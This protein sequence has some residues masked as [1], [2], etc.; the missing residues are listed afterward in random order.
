MNRPNICVRYV[1]R[2]LA[3]ELHTR[4]LLDRIDEL[5][6]QIGAA[7]KAFTEAREAR[8][9]DEALGAPYLVPDRS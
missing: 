5:R 2:D 6:D 4:G 9:L 8:L 1:C 3:R 7:Y